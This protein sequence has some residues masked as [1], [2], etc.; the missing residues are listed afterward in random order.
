MCATGAGGI[1]L[2]EAFGVMLSWLVGPLPMRLCF[3]VQYCTFQYCMMSEHLVC[4]PA[5][6]TG[7]GGMAL[8]PSLCVP[9][10][11]GWW[12]HR[13]AVRTQ[14]R[15][16]CLHT[17][18]ASHSDAAAHPQRSKQRRKG[19][20]E[21]N[22]RAR[23]QEG[24][25]PDSLPPRGQGHPAHALPYKGARGRTTAMLLVNLGLEHEHHEESA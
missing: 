20:P 16:S 15:R 10:L 13:V 2:L 12:A 9:C 4:A 19:A 22:A 8:L 18:W 24:A 21:R 23:S 6:Q 3:T 11:R 14:R 17:P 7:R 25:L 1:A 5:E